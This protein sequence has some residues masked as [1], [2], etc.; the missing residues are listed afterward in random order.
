MLAHRA[1][2][3][4]SDGTVYRSGL[5]AWLIAI[6]IGVAAAGVGALTGVAGAV[7]ADGGSA[8]ADVE[9]DSPDG[10]NTV[11]LPD[12][13]LPSPPA[14]TLTET[15][16]DGPLL[17]PA[18]RLAR[19]LGFGPGGHYGTSE[20]V[21]IEESLNRLGYALDGP[22]RLEGTHLHLRLK[23]LRVIRSVRVFGNFPLLDDEILRHLSFASGTQLP[24]DEAVDGFL[25]EEAERVHEFLWREG[26]F[27]NKVRIDR[28]DRPKEHSVDLA[29]RVD[30]GGWT[31]PFVLEGV[32]PTGNH[33]ITDREL[34][35]T[36]SHGKS[37][38]GRFSLQRMRDD[39]RKAEQLLKD[40]GYPAARVVPDFDEKRDA[41]PERRRVMLP[42]KIMEKRR[43]D[44]KFVGNRA[45]GEKDLRD[46]LTIF[47]TG[48]YDEIELEESARSI[49][50]YY[51]QHGNFE[52]RVAFR[53]RRI[54]AGE[55]NK[56]DKKPAP[57][58]KPAPVGKAADETQ[59]EDAEEVT[60]L[61]DEGPELRVREVEVVSEDGSPLAF[62]SE[63]LATKAA[64]ETKVFPR[65]G[66]IGLGSGGYVTAV[67]LQQ[68]VDRLVE[69]YKARGYPNA[70][71]RGEVARDPS[72]FAGLGALGASGASAASNQTDLYVRFWI[73]QG[74]HQVCDDVEISFVGEHLKKERELLKIITL[75]PG[76]AFTED[77]LAD[78]A[79]RILA[80]YKTLGRPYVQADYSG[81]IWNADKTRI[82]VRYRVSE[83]PE[84][85]FG[86]ILIRGNFKTRSRVIMQD[87]PFRAGE[88]FDLKKLE[89]GERNLQTHFIFDSVRLT[90]VGLS[91]QR[92]PVPILVTVREKYLDNG[93]L[94]FS[95]GVSSDRL[96][97]YWYASVSYLWA[98]FFGFGSQLELKA[99][100]DWINSW[101]VLG[102]Y[103]D[104][105]IFGP[106]WRFD[107]TGY[108]RKELTNRVGELAVFGASL[109]LSRYIT[110]ALRAYLRYDFY[111]SQTQVDVSRLP[112][113]NDTSATT[114]ST[115]TAKL[116][117]GIA[118]DRR[119]G[120][121]GQPNPLAP[122]KGWLLQAQFGVATPY[123]GGDH[124][125]LVLAA[126]A[127]A[128]TPFKI[129]KKQFHFLANLRY[130]EGI[131]LDGPAL[132]V[133]ERYFAGGE[134]STRGYE[135]DELKTEIVRSGVSPLT[136][137]AG[138]RVVPQGGNVRVLSTLEIQFPIA[139]T[140]LGLP[141]R[142]VGAVF[143]DA[144]TV[145][146]GWNVLGGRD[147]KNSIGGT[148]LRVLTPFGPLSVEYAYPLNEGL[149]EQRWKTNP[150]YSHWPG[151]IHFNWGI[152]LA[153]F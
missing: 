32:Q 112:G 146:D 122:F 78:D 27:G 152:P 143:W 60:F 61:I 4:S 83:G 6:A 66:A 97:Y 37:I 35:D 124:T 142:W 3:A 8:P 110:Q 10:G 34:Y 22:P 71:A 113:T 99:D 82:R 56:S 85:R 63:E 92:N 48:A 26:Y 18:D 55:D 25:K 134:T 49:Q 11:E 29:V 30:L 20:A 72:A 116:N 150:W 103:T 111:F 135:P 132:P 38:W 44:V 88:L 144:G 109:A 54:A 62:S 31:R 96:P 64:L 147:I 53:R 133:V 149:A 1:M 47:T 45:I 131:P 13:G 153:R 94:T 127:L 100:F 21:G 121:D 46:Q 15:T 119:V 67:Q 58:A 68:D 43:V 138:F 145:F 125:F 28:K 70:T 36:F 87:L 91:N 39:A 14:I 59:R 151:R 95:I 101:G 93:R 24:P 136:G 80:A 129:R 140:F 98:N 137:A 9:V 79:R 90:P 2:R 42:V 5:R 19:F 77:K 108:Y 104:P 74:V 148:F 117:L 84:V 16:I 114:D 126:Q 12:G 33:A 52:A 141:W 7:P 73:N 81:S 57:T 40:R 51:Q 86:E 105:R 41:D 115:R 106:N 123:L 128:I 76:V 69:Y 139:D 102:R 23:P 107:T 130:D 50:R 65:L 17:E 75:K 118:W 89:E 120:A